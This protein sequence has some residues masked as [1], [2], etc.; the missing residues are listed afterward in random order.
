MRDFRDKSPW[1]LSSLGDGYVNLIYSLALFRALGKPV[2]KK[3]ANSVLSKALEAAGLRSLAGARA[4]SHR[5]ADYA[6][7]YL[8]KAWA[9]GKIS[10]EESVS[11]LAKS[12]SGS[13]DRVTLR[14]E[15]VEAFASLLKA[16]AEKKTKKKTPLLTVDAVVERAGKVLLVR[17]RNPPY[18]GCWALPGGFVEYGE[19]VEDAVVRE[20]KEETGLKIS[21]K[22]LLGVY[23]EPGRDPRGHVVSI[24]FLATGEGA[25]KGGSDVAE[26]RFFGIEEIDFNKLAFDH[27]KIL[28][29]YIRGKRDVL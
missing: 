20:L 5:L 9:E 18:K 14:K 7:G 21:I 24:C 27:E 13:E 10:L 25:E 3:V 29:D 12:F 2:G 22:G 17:R 26:A 23:S 1:E 16:V 28:K 8:F 6:E 19:S 15:S 4:D 11:I